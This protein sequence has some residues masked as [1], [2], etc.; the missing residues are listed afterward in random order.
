MPTPDSPHFY[1]VQK[2][3]NPPMRRFFI[4][5]EDITETRGTIEGDEAR[6]MIQVLRLKPGVKII[7]L[8]GQGKEYDAVI[9]E[10]REKS[11]SVTL[12][13]SREEAAASVPSVTICQAFL[14]EKKMDE[15]VR[16]LTE[17]GM[18]SFQSFFCSRVVARP[19]G[20]KLAKREARWEKIAGEAVK[21]CGRTTAPV[22][23]PTLELKDLL[24]KLPTGATTLKLFF[25]EEAQVSFKEIEALKATGITDIT[26]MIGPEGGFTREEAELAKASGFLIAGLG[27]RIL[28]AETAPLAALAIV[29]FLFGDM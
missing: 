10:I 17:L 11:V 18:A 4:K 16:H 8:D 22:I 20:D 28:R 21:Q 23:C 19:K 13:G 9:H 27:K 12:T 3:R 26:L 6:H 5:K 14:K 15:L 29:Q 2:E 1:D 7:L 24:K 25:W